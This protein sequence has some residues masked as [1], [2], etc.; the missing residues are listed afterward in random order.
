MISVVVPL[1]PIHP[2]DQQVEVL[3]RSLHNQPGVCEVLVVE[4][5]PEG[6]HPLIRMN[7]LFNIGI[8]KAKGSYIWLCGADFIVPRY[9]PLKMKSKCYSYYDAFLPM[10]QSPA[11][12]NW[13]VSDGGV[14]MKR[15]VIEKHGPLDESLIGVSRISFPFLYWLLKNCKVGWSRVITFEINTHPKSKIFGKVHKK[16]REKC[17][18][19][20]DAC[21]GILGELI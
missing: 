13:K 1:M 3:L 15:G 9:T 5:E 19:F 6:R 14:F 7:K 10:Y 21:K 20:Y 8:A 17:T 16:T 11:I 12:G 2:Y 18:P 4:Q